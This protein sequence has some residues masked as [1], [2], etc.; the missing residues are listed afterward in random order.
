MACLLVPAVA[1]AQ[2]TPLGDAGTARGVPT[3]AAAQTSTAPLIDGRLDEEAWLRAPVISVFTQRDPDEGLPA[4]ERT[5][6]R[7]IY[8]DDAMYVGARL[9]DRQ[10][11]TTRL[12]RRDMDLSSSD[13][14]R[15]SFDS[16]FDRR[17]AY[18]FDV[19]PSG[20]RRDAILVG[21]GSG[22]G[23]T[24]P[25]GDLAW[26]AVWDAGTTID[27]DG[28]TAELRI[29][30]SQLRFVSG[31]D[32]WGLQVE[33][34]LNRRQELSLFAFSRK[35]EPGGVPAFGTLTGLT[36][37]R[38][39]R[40]LE[41]IPY[42]LSGADFVEAGGNPFRRNRELHAQAGVDARYAIT[43][44]LTLTTT[45]NP[46]FG[47][48]E[49]DP[50]VI[51]LTAFETR[52][53]ER[54]PFFVEGA[55][56]F[57]FAGALGGPSA[58]AQNM[59]YSRR[60]GR[61]PQL[62][63]DG[64]SHVPDTARILGAAKITGKTATGWS[65]GVL[66][67]VTGRE[68]GRFLDASGR[69]A[70]ALTEP[71]TNFF[72]GRLNRELR[73]GQTTLGPIFTAVTRD[74]ADPRAA[75]V[76]HGG[77]YAGGM[78]F[79]HE[80]ADRTWNIAGFAVGSRVTGSPDAILRTQRTSTRYFQ[81]P[82][83]KTFS[84][85][86]SRTS[87]DGFAASVQFRKVSGTHWTGDGWVATTSPGFEMNN[88]GFQ[89]RAD[90]HAAGGGVR[91]QQLEPGRVLRSWNLFTGNDFALNWDGDLVDARSFLRGTAQLLNYWSISGM[92]R[93]EPERQDDRFTRGGP[94][95]LAPRAVAQELAIS[96]D[97]RRAIGADL[98]LNRWRNR[99]G[100]QVNETEFALRVRTSPRWNL[101]VGPTYLRARQDVQYVTTIADASATGT[102]GRRYIFAP[103][104][105]K[106]LG[107]VTRLN[108]TFTRD[109]TLEVYAQPLVSHADYGTPKEFQRPSGYDFGVYGQDLGA[110]ARTNDAYDVQVPHAG[111]TSTFRVP[112][113]SFTTRS[114]RGNAVLRWEYRPGSTL[115]VVWQQERLNH[116]VMPSFGLNRAVGSLFDAHA[117]NVLAVKWSYWLNP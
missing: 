91:Y 15:V 106:E 43:S 102:F 99:A 117:N 9:H 29:P 108:Y 45:V 73:G 90:R 7:V 81:R 115:F 103:L 54:R 75:G 19:N 89:Q 42:V 27:E 57:R 2:S 69:H 95:A 56:S 11:A 104:D 25:E 63:L 82:D 110:I 6:V 109:L 58:L 55:A 101:T 17:T 26:D 59:F 85:D 96:S 1:H 18:R 78:D 80:W 67:A 60:I 76:L 32:M 93:N 12:G 49:V 92:V 3:V 41:I 46:D 34:I 47:Q 39:G 114:L 88:L 51:N 44:N 52:F 23:F 100:S 66:N 28:W 68:D 8:D 111:G 94:L 86:P 65:V 13:W 61:A 112:D 10:P 72:V 20:V 107:I 116:D 79:V 21:G 71:L 64:P 40:R 70:T 84:V 30:F 97:P 24:G 37:L 36:G 38:V 74:V 62:G 35:S 77:A 16:Y 5:D 50:A 98:Q 105:Q 31:A 33:R 4:T 87:L 48:V 14:F 83:A 113:R 22:G 53:E